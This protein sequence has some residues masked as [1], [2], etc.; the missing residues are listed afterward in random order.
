MV[1][2]TGNNRVQRIGGGGTRIRREHR[3]EREKRTLCDGN[4]LTGTHAAA[5]RSAHATTHRTATTA[6]LRSSF[7]T[8]HD[9]WMVLTRG[10]R[11]QGG[12]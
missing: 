5:F 3:P 10:K 11:R 4:G 9:E 1:A 2:R 7:D 8:A 12:R 6:G